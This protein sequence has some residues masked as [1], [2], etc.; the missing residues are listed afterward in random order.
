MKEIELSET[1]SDA[2]VR[3]DPDNIIH[4]RLDRLENQSQEL[5]RQ[6]ERRVVLA[7]LKVEAVLA[8]MIDLDGLSFLDMTVIRLDDN[9]N[10]TGGAEMI[11][12]LKREKPWLFAVPSSSSTARVPMS[13]PTRQKLATE[14]T[15]DEYRIARA[16]IIKRSAR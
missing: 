7:E 2:D 11:S 3:E 1:T 16:D 15:D 9:G 12:Q 6:S 4:A 8:G 14:M 5:L 10:V 13:R